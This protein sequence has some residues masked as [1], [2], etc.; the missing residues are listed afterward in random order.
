MANGEILNW[1]VKLVANISD[2][3]SLPFLYKG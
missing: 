3:N 2:K 1:E